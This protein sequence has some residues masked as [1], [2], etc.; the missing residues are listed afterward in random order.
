MR[1]P[2]VAIIGRPNVGKSSIFNWLSGHRIAIVDD[3]AGVTRDRMSHLMHVEDRFFDLVDT[4]GIGINDVDNLTKEIEQ[5]IEQAIE[6]ADVI[7][8]TVDTRS[9]IT[10]LDEEV[11]R[12]LRYI[13]KPIICVANKADDPK[14][15]PQADE[16][17]RL[18]R[19]KLVRVSA[20]QNRNKHIL[21]DLLLER[22]PEFKDATDAAVED[23]SLIHI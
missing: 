14:L 2:Q 11:A 20:H 15:D 21:L 23:L 13:E 4:G 17:Y 19:G 3:V 1:V 8:F 10:P 12:R 22:L 7:L 16:F 6:V 9:G 18:G 5:Q